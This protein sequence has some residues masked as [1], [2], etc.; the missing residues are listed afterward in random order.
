MTFLVFFLVLFLGAIELTLRKPELKVEIPKIDQNLNKVFDQERSSSY[1]DLIKG[2]R[3]SS[4]QNGEN[5][6]S[7]TE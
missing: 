2:L 6:T 5:E 1:S 7:A 3:E 4:G